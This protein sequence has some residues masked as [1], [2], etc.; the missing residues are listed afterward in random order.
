MSA[1]SDAADVKAVINVLAQR[2]QH[3]KS[4]SQMVETILL[5]TSGRP[6]GNG[7]RKADPVVVAGKRQTLR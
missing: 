1:V 7:G 6:C 2:L 4:I 5:R 3:V